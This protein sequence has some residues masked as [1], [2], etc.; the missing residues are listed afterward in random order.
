GEG[1][2]AGFAEEAG[3]KMGARISNSF[4]EGVRV[5]AIV[6]GVKSPSLFGQAKAAGGAQQ[7]VATSSTTVPDDMID[8]FM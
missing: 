8:K 1:V 7:M 6:T 3:V 2:S 5:T 4:M